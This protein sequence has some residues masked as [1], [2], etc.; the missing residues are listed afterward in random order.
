MVAARIRF[1]RQTQVA[2]Q[3]VDA[4]LAARAKTGLS[5]AA[6]AIAYTPAMRTVVSESPNCVDAAP[7]RC[8]NCARSESF[9]RRYSTTSATAITAPTT[10]GSDALTA[11]PPLPALARSKRSPLIHHVA[12]AA[13][14]TP[15]ATAA[16][17]AAINGIRGLRRRTAVAHVR[18]TTPEGLGGP[19]GPR[20][21]TTDDDA[22]ND[23][24]RHANGQPP[25][26]RQAGSSRHRR[27]AERPIHRP[28]RGHR[29]G[30]DEHRQHSHRGVAQ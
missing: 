15:S 10:A 21:Q 8:A 25:S 24:R 16:V 26:N 5:S 28:P 6:A 2:A 18:R 4:L 19:E 3:H 17:S 11:P 14:P 23:S 1:V 9:W 13:S 12:K 29:G 30:H 27:K 7:N 20:E 22:D